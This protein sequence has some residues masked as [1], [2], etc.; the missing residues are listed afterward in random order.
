MAQYLL[1][2][3]SFEEAMAFLGAFAGII[4]A[5]I[6]LINSSVTRLYRYG[7]KTGEYNG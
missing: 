7:R 2:D 6:F 1:D 3:T 5:C 4:V